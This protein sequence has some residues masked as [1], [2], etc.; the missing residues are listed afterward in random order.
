MRQILYSKNSA[1]IGKQANSNYERYNNPTV[2]ALFDQ[3]PTASDADQVGIIQKIEA[4]MLADVPII[5]TTESVD[6]FQYNTSDIQGWPTKD[7]PYAQPAAYN[8]PDVE[9]LLLHLYSQNA[10]NN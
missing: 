9:Q 7:N 6:W 4:A 5:P 1:P 2:D 8:V 10:Q 3:Y